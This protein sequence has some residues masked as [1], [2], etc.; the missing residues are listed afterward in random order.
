MKVTRD[1][2]TD[3]WALYTSNEASS[4]TRA[5]VED[6]LKGDPELARALTDRKPN[7]IETCAPVPLPPDHEMRTLARVKRHLWG[8]RPLLQLALVFSCIAFGRIIS[9]T[10]WDVSP[11]NFIITASIAAGFWVAFFTTLYRGRRSLFIRG[12]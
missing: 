3:L 10:S 8:Y 4:D 6:F 2:I 1:V 12:R 11:R 7:M 9:D 5:L